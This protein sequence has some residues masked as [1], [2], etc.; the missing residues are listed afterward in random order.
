LGGLFYEDWGNGDGAIWGTV[1]RWKKNHSFEFT[2]RCGMSGAVHGIICFSLDAKGPS[3]TILKLE[4]DAIG[5][6]SEKTLGG[7]TYGWN[8]LL[9]KRL[10]SYVENGVCLGIMQK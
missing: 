7:Y 3:S 8:D 10:K 5:Q 1:T 9:E 6:L 4:H 2:G